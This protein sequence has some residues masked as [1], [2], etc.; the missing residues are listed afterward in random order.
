MT[1]R[2]ISKID[3][4]TSG[5]LVIDMQN[6]F[7]DP[8]GTLGSDGADVG[9]IQTVMDPLRRVITACRRSGVPDFWSVQEHYEDDATRPRHRLKPHTLKRFRV[10]ALKG[11]WDAEIVNQLRDLI[12]EKSEVF[13]KNRFGCFYNTQL[14]NLLRLHGIDTLFVAGVDTNV[15]VE[16]TVREA[17]M[18]DLDVVVLKDCVGGVH[19]EWAR[20]AFEVWDRYIGAVIDSEEL[21]QLLERRSE[22]QS[23]AMVNTG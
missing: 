22:G 13:V 12:D 8:K 5:L 9:R 4:S 3:L 11:T 1:S 19:E 16:T 20:I 17:Y 6:A 18:R 10:P 15:C 23:G 2:D 7:C 14:E 21:I